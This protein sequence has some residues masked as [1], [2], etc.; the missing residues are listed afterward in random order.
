MMPPMGTHMRACSFAA[1]LALLAGCGGAV[2]SEQVLADLHQAIG[3]PVG[4]PD[5]NAAHSRLVDVALDGSV[6]D[7]RHRAE[8]QELIGRGDP[9]SRH[10][11]CG[12]HGFNGDDWFYTVGVA[13]EGY[14]EH[15]PIL[16]V[17]FDRHGR[18]DRTW[19][20]RTHE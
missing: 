4:D 16:I 12:A 18:V 11:R 10:P 3:A 15:L 19:N 5:T 7:D 8:V 20:L 13:A 1:S 6:L 9:C 14:P 17:G 2:N